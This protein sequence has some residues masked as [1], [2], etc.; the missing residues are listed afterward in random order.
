MEA[1]ARRMTT[2]L[3]AIGEIA[4]DEV[5]EEAG[6]PYSCPAQHLHSHP[7]DNAN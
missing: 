1:A 6:I 2:L 3:K 4:V 5:D 7:S